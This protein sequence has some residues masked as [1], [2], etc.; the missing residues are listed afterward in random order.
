MHSFFGKYIILWFRTKPTYILLPLFLKVSSYLLAEAFLS[1]C[2]SVLADELR[3][4]N[5][6]SYLKLAQDICCADLK[7]TVFTY[8]SRNM[9][10]LSHLIR[11]TMLNDLITW[12]EIFGLQLALLNWKIILSTNFNN[13]LNLFSNQTGSWDSYRH[14][15]S[16]P[17]SGLNDWLRVGCLISVQ[18]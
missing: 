2:L 10:E 4:D 1:R 13:S 8:L 7:M 15:T 18:S 12:H 3:P 16:N 6:L 9:M 5:C 11:Y 17:S 14:F